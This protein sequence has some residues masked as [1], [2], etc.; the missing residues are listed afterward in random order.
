VNLAKDLGVKGLFTGLGARLVMVGSLT[1]FQ[2]AI[3]GDIKRVL[4]AT[5]GTEIAAAK[6]K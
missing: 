5:G 1:A 6:K 4:N 2:F 3:Y